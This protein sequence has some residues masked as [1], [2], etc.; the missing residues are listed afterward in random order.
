VELLRELGAA[1]AD[2]ETSVLRTVGQEVDEAL[3]AA[4]ARLEGILVF[5][6]YSQLQNH[7]SF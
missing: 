2:D 6:E 3:E 1:F 7:C 5:I 4:E